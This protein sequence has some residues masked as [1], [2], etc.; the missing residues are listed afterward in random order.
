MLRQRKRTP[1]RAEQLQLP[2]TAALA[3]RPCASMLKEEIVKDPAH[4]L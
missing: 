2:V 1:G 4:A 3:G